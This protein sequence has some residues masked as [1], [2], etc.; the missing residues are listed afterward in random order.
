MIRHRPAGPWRRRRTNRPPGET[1]RPGRSS[2]RSRSTGPVSGSGLGRLHAESRWRRTGPTCSDG[3]TAGL[4]IPTAGNRP[5]AKDGGPRPGWLPHP[6]SG[7]DDRSERQ[8][9]S[10][11]DDGAGSQGWSQEPVV[12]VVAVVPVPQEGAGRRWIR[13]RDGQ[14][15]DV[16]R[17]R[18]GPGRH[19]PAADRPA[20]STRHWG[21]AGWPGPGW[22]CPASRGTGRWRPRHTTTNRPEV[23]VARLVV[24]A[25][26]VERVGD[27]RGPSSVCD[28]APK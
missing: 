21:T 17:G 20:G 3:A 22:R 18:R 24:R 28:G 4:R 11:L 5:A 9:A 12:P 7:V 1:V 27:R 13:S 2:D 6:G 16:G 14:G 26:R 8:G 25:V 15:V 10:A 19:P 23:V